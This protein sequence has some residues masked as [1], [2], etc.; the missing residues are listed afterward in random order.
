M[1]A[2]S[3]RTIDDYKSKQMSKNRSRELQNQRLLDEAMI[4]KVF[5]CRFQYF[6]S[7]R[8]DNDIITSE[9]L[10]CL[11]KMALQKNHEE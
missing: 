8:E 10:D 3:Q 7:S 11:F 5:Y 2:S 4:K 9:F 6:I 1:I